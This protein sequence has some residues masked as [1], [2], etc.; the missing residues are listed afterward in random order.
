VSL[1]IKVCGLTSP[2]EARA[3]VDAG[4]DMIGLNFV[5]GSPRCL[6]VA[7]G[8]RIADAVRGAVEIVGVTADLDAA[9]LRVLQSSV[10]LDRLQLHGDE[11]PELLAE[12]GA[13]A[14]KVVR[15]GAA[16]DVA[17]ARRYHCSPL[18]VD[19]RVPGA[20]GGTG[21]RVDAALVAGLAAE[22]AVLLAGGLTPENVAE[23]VR[24][25][26]PWGVDVASGVELRPGVKDVARV[27]A[28]VVAA[29]G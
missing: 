15:V 10:G 25:V 21:V 1:R 13:A 12:L 20:L 22:R 9:A 27:T 14:F 26:R 7:K 23:A 6:D 16:E 24:A 3:C 28:F 4:V 8:R 17:A 19:A 11:A 29:R 2:T 18:L 5:P